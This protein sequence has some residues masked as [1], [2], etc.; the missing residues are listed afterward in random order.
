MELRQLEYLVSVVDHGGFT[1]AAEQVRVAQPGVSAQ[2]RRLERE[3]G[4]P[5]LDRSGRAVRPTEAGLAVLPW[6]RAALAAAAGVRQAVDELS[7]LVRGHL[8]VGTVTAH[9]VDL[10]ALLAE[11]H[12]AHPGVVITL[13]EDGSDRLVAATLDGTLDAA[14]VA[15]GELPAG[16][17]AHVVADTPVVAAVAPGDPLAE[18]TELPL[19]GLRGRPLVTFPRGGGVRAILEQACAA[20]GFRPEVAF[21]AGS[22]TLV[23]DLAARGLGTAILPAPAARDRADLHTLALV[24]PTPRGRL[25][26]AWRDAGPVSPAARAFLRLVVSRVPAGSRP[27]PG[28]AG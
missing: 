15:Y 4:Q 13:T 18:R 3:L 11:F 23:A 5:L 12:R 16:L 1:R 6:A 25:A 7:G 10:P 8:A 9:N 26:V 2:V 21:E 20:A 14:I 19:A 27:R 17:R 24:D 22:P 28:S